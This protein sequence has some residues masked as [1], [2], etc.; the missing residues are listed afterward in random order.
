MLCAILFSN[1]L[2]SDLMFGCCWF[3]IQLQGSP[4]TPVNSNSNSS[5]VSDPSAPW[6][7]SEELDSGANNSYYGGENELLG[8]YR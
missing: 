3:M 2:P 7:L 5:S 8:D 1:Q 6:R 4:G